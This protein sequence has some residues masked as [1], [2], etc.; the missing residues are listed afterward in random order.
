MSHRGSPSSLDSL[1]WLVPGRAHVL[2]G[3]PGTGKTTFCLRFV[4]AGL[5][6]GER[7]AMLAMCRAADI[8]AHARRLGFDLNEALRLEQLVL[9]RY[10]A[11]FGE[12][13]ARSTSPRD[14]VDE[15]ERSFSLVSPSRIV[16]DSFAP[17]LGDEPGGGQTISALAAYLERS[18]ATS[19]LT[20]PEDVSAGYDRRLEPVMQGAAAIL[21]LD[22]IAADRVDLHA[23][24]MR[25]GTEPVTSCDV[26][27]TSLAP[28]ALTS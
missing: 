12:R 13:R 22:R 17:F 11:D 25:G 10:P 16:I 4:A 3:G 8:K 6:A 9:L 24:T 1:E 18:G 28:I 19:V 21:R 2:L 23:L 14:A 5:A 27:H 26:P 7:V 20:Y 15:L